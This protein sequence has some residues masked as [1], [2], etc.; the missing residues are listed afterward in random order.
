MIVSAHNELVRSP[1]RRWTR[2]IT[3]EPLSYDASYR[4]VLGFWMDRKDIRLRIAP[5]DRK[6]WPQESLFRDFFTLR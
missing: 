1:A 2:K 4:D 3:E 6:Q 5:F